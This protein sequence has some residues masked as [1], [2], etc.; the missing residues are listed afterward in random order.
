MC[1]KGLNE[2]TAPSAWSAANWPVQTLG[3]R[4]KQNQTSSGLVTAWLGDQIVIFYLFQVK[5]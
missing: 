1:A 3:K 5:L 2:R 4:I